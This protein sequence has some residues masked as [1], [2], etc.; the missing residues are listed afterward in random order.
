M[1]RHSK[2]YN[3]VMDMFNTIT[4]NYNELE[5]DVKEKEVINHDH[6]QLERGNRYGGFDTQVYGVSTIVDAMV[7]IYMMKHNEL[8]PMKNISEW[9]YLAIKLVRIPADVS[10]VDNYTDLS[11]YAKLLQD[12][13]NGSGLL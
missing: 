1:D 12:S 2:A 13:Y 3:E 6:I 8:P 9:H 4:S 11:V 7:H 5:E 10:Y